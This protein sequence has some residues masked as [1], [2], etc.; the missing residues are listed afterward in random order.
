MLRDDGSIAPGVL[1]GHHE[2]DRA[3]VTT[4]QVIAL[5]HVA[6][7]LGLE[8]DNHAIDL[9]HDDFARTGQDEIDGLAVLTRRHLQGDVPGCVGN[10]PKHLGDR[11]LARVA[12]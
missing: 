3:L 8:V 1:D 10:G 5:P 2:P 12:E 11:E 6:P 4:G 9:D 7:I